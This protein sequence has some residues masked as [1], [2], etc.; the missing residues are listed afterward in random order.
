MGGRGGRDREVGLRKAAVGVELAPPARRRGELVGEHREPDV[1]ALPVADLQ[2]PR[3]IPLA[4]EPETLDE[5]DR[6]RVVGLD[7]GLDAVQS[8]RAERMSQHQAE[9]LEHVSAAL[10]RDERRVPEVRAPQ[11][12]EY[13]VTEAR[14]AGE[15]VVV[16]SADE[17]GLAEGRR[18]MSRKPSAV[19]GR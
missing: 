15:R 11:V 1:V 2:V 16:V 9:T 14:A 7:V 19:S 8:Q 5:R 17:V 10:K 18:S 3:R 4:S 6:T 13:D 12:A